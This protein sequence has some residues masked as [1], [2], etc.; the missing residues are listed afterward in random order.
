LALSHQHRQLFLFD[1]SKDSS[2]VRNDSDSGTMLD[3]DKGK[4][5]T[6]PFTKIKSLKGEQAKNKT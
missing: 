2:K 1:E 6:A 3:A 4:T 5:L